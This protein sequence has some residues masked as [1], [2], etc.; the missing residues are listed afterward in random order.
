[1]Y[2]D[3]KAELVS[4][5]ENTTIRGVPRFVKTKD[6]VLKKLWVLFLI[7]CTVTLTF[8]LYVA[9]SKYNYWPIRTKYG[10]KVEGKIAFP[11]ITI[12]NLDSFA[13]GYP[14]I[15]PIEEFLL[16][17]FKN[18][19]MIL[20]HLVK[21][22]SFSQSYAQKIYEEFNS[23]TGYI[24]NIPKNCDIK[25]D[26]PDFIIQCQIHQSNWPDDN[27]DCSNYFEKHWSP[28][29]YVCYTL[30][31][32]KLQTLSNNMSVRGLY[33]MLNIGP[34]SVKQIPYQY[35]FT[36]SQARGVQV[37][38][39]RSGTPPSP[40][41]GFSVAPGTENIVTI[42]QTEKHRLDKPYNKFGCTAETILNVS[43]NEFYT[44]DSCIEFCKQK[45]ILK[46]CG[47]VSH[48]LEVPLSYM[49]TTNMCG[50][51]SLDSDQIKEHGFNVFL[52]N[53]NVSDNFQCSQKFLKGTCESS[54]LTPCDETIYG[55]FLST[56]S[57]PQNSLQIDLFENF[58]Y[59]KNC[60][61]THPEVAKRYKL[62]TDILEH[63]YES[64]LTMTDAINTNLKATSMK[65][66][67]IQESFL[68]I[69]FI[70]K[71]DIPYY[72]IEEA[73]YTWDT[74]VGVVGG[75]LS[76]WLGVS[77]ATFM[78]V[79]DFVYRLLMKRCQKKSNTVAI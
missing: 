78:E 79:V 37:D 69:K 6:P 5:A 39:H 62:Y 72:D 46:N 67:Q 60:T 25:M 28:N 36:R 12:C 31:T 76:L 4:Y 19:K 29:Y 57:W 20:E 77:A 52:M 41:N 22:E 44:R 55:T 58:I 51:F 54:C 1:M 64:N 45:N 38:V 42:V 11:D 7:A 66:N 3:F 23:I 30:K 61:K 47:C 16:L 71:E 49:N 32:S 24:L 68:T 18:K 43:P 75:M 33:L 73:A 13:A 27:K 53:K 21:N 10:E 35:S 63:F 17:F 34:P 56:A 70:I 50:N 15:L 9:I 65:L 8:F 40:K 74:M 2:S 48:Y 14:E 26:C 59:E